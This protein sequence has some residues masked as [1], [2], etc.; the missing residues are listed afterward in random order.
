[1]L[2]VFFLGTAVGPVN[3]CPV[4]VV[5]P[6]LR[7]FGKGTNSLCCVSSTSSFGC[8]G[9]L[10]LRTRMFQSP[11][12]NSHRWL[13]TQQLLA[14]TKWAFTYCPKRL[15]SFDLLPK[16]LPFS[17]NLPKL[18][19]IRI[20]GIPISF[21]LC[22]FDKTLTSE[23]T[24]WVLEQQEILPKNLSCSEYLKIFKDNYLKLFFCTSVL[25]R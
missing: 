21:S 25:L 7:C 6:E 5:F 13:S 20:R 18:Q 11:V 1:M 12:C 2:L 24:Q 10:P 15:L 19:D 23:A 16:G 3:T 14:C 17:F 9:L 22:L 4:L 8:P